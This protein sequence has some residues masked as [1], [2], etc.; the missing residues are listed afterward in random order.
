MLGKLFKHQMKSVSKV[1]IIIHAALLLFGIVLGIAAP[2]LTVSTSSLS[3]F[4]LMFIISMTLYI[5]ILIGVMYTTHILLAIRFYRNMFTSEGY[6]THTLPV[7]PGTLL[8]SHILT[9]SVWYMICMLVILLSGAFL[10]IGAGGVS[11]LTKL[12]CSLPEYFNTNMFMVIFWILQYLIIGAVSSA[13]MIY[14]S[15]TIGSLFAPH[16]VIASI[17]TYI[18]F[19][20]IIQISTM[21]LMMASPTMRSVMFVQYSV[22]GITKEIFHILLWSELEL[23]L[24]TAAFWIT[25]HIILT[26]H[27]N[28]E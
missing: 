13:T 22:A 17:V 10:V 4:E 3:I 2:S 25:S 14:A 21:I 6:L 12:I 18:I 9:F 27:L 28:L 8:F 23:I 5:F 24:F 11:E 16:K 19:Y 20:A 26:K 7:K 15:I 1:L